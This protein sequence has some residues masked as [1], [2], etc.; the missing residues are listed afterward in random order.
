MKDN[1]EYGAEVMN[2]YCNNITIQAF[3]GT[4]DKELENKLQVMKD[5]H[6][7][8]FNE[9]A[10]RFGYRRTI[11]VTLLRDILPEFINN[12]KQEEERIREEHESRP[13]LYD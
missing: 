9:F 12:I 1:L 3:I 11:K 8:R 4:L 2:W 6:A 10:K 5:I 7:S 13:D